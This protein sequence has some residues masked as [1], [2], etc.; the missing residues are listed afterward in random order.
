ML[1]NTFKKK[2]KKKIFNKIKLLIV[3]HNAPILHLTIAPKLN[4]FTAP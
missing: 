3:L 1:I 4:L 2:K